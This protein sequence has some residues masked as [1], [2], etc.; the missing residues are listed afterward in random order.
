MNIAK[1]RLA[2]ERK[3]WRKEHPFGFIAKPMPSSDGDS[4][5]LFRWECKIPGKAGVSF[6]EC[7]RRQDLLSF[8]NY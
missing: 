6:F 2:Q 8:F 1:Q 4:V 5:D 7:L 3:N